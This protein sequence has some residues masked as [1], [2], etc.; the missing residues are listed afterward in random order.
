MSSKDPV[1]PWKES[2]SEHPVSKFLLY[3]FCS[4]E[5]TLCFWGQEREVTECVGQFLNLLLCLFCSAEFTGCFRGLERE[6]TECVDQFLN[7]LLCLF[8]SAEFTVC[9]RG[10]EREVTECVGEGGGDTTLGNGKMSRPSI[11]C[12]AVVTLADIQ[13]G[14]CLSGSKDKVCG[15]LTVPLRY[16][17]CVCVCVCVCV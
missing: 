9:F 5:F 2:F 16:F 8:C 14:L 6:V 11:H 3:L 4:A 1:K 12:D 10:Q 13:P 15:S 17:N 7:L